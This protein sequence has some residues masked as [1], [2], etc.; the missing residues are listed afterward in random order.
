MAILRTLGYAPAEILQLVLGESVLISVL[1]GVAGLG[2]GFVL[3]KGMRGAFGFTGIKWQAVA[4]VLGMAAII[5]LFAALVPAMIA[6]RK[7]V[8]EAI[9]F[10]G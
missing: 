8:V 5:G 3:A 7:N 6:S 10:T 2:I 1:G 9:R 4:I